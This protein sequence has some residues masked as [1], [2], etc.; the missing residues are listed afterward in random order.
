MLFTLGRD[1]PAGLPGYTGDRGLPGSQGNPGPPGAGGAVYTRWG[2]TT[3]GSSSTVI[4][5]GRY[6]K[7]NYSNQD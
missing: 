3:C 7:F 5:T 4:Y 2:R 1:G 6:V